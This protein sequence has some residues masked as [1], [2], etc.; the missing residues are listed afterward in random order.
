MTSIK[1][2]ALAAA[3]VAGIGMFSASGAQA[4]P[5][6]FHGHHFHG[7]GHHHHHGHFHGHRG[8]LFGLGLVGAVAVGGAVIA[9]SCYRTRW[10]DTPYGLVRR[11]VNIC[12]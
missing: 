12:D 10:V 11:T 5:F 9:S 3:A 4:G 1:T 6:G 7:H 2:L 8:R